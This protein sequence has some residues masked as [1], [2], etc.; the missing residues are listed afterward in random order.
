M[1]GLSP[2]TIF[3]LLLLGAAIV[4][5]VARFRP[6]FVHQTAVVVTGLTL[7]IWL[8]L[9][10][11][12]PLAGAPAEWPA[13]RVPVWNWRVDESGWLLGGLL[14]FLVAAVLL[15][16][17]SQRV[18][19][20]AASDQQP[21]TILLLGAAGLAVLWAGTLAAVATGW[22]LLGVAWAVH[23]LLLDEVNHNIGQL[24]PKMGWLLVGLL[25]LWLAAANVPVGLAM[26]EWPLVTTTSVLLAAVL[27]MGVWPL[28]RWQPFDW[29]LPPVVAVLAY[30]VPVVA[31]STWLTRLVATSQVGLAYSLFLTVFG[32]LGLLVA[33]RL[34]WS[35]LQT[36]GRMIPTLALAQTSLILLAGV[37]AGAAAAVAEARVLLLA[38]GT[39]FL[40]QALPV[41]GRPGWR[42]RWRLVASLIALGALAGWPLTAGFAGRAALYNAWLASGRFTLVVVAALIHVPLVGAVWLLVWRPEEP[43]PLAVGTAEVRLRA[44]ELAG[45]LGLLLLV[46][47]LLSISSPPWGDIGPITWLAVLLPVAAGL[48]LPRFLGEVGEVR[49]ALRRAFSFT[50]PWGGLNDSLGQV[51]RGMGV[52]IRE[53]ASILEGEGGLL[54]LLAL[55][56]IFLLTR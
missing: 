53:A 52:V 20:P 47:A 5:A 45:D 55:T 12:L 6:H 42:G 39:L 26:I 41:N 51:I 43:A 35:H 13:A 49:A 1:I 18:N 9:R 25:P 46:I 24:W 22:T 38:V 16:A 19:E 2:L 44:S 30:T 15:V 11:R 40:S 37:W 28:H 3:W 23:L 10:P 50:R 34:A 54:W 36:P 29:P 32:L 33:V 56:I 48:A 7:L 4:S 27:L 17:Y 14:L 31:G 21:T 8:A